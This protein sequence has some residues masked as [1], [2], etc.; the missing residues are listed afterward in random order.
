VVFA[1]AWRAV[2]AAISA[3]ISFV[4]A[5]KKRRFCRLRIARPLARFCRTLLRRPPA[6]GAAFA[7]CAAQEGSVTPKDFGKI[8]LGLPEAWEGSHMGHADF[9]VGKRIFAT[10]GYPDASSGMVRLTLSQQTELVKRAP[11]VFAP[12]PG[13]WGRKG[14][15]QVR[16]VAA[17]RRVLQPALLTAWANIAPRRLTARAA[18]RISPALARAYQ[19]YLRIVL[20]LPGTS[21]STSY[22]TPSV[23]VA[24]KLLSRWRTEAE[25]GLAIRCDFLDRQILLANADAF[26]LTD[27]YRDYPM[28]LVR[29]ERVDP[30]A[31][32]DLTRRAWRMVAPKKLL[33]STEDSERPVD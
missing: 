18:P 9:R 5:G 3:D 4:C 28:V 10:L 8:A 1:R 22:G 33:K 13:G 26:F 31:L 11:R 27:H 6:K 25:G 7:G 32:T 2:P 23:K 30:R 29:L 19:R 15:T 12:V 21:E 14:S 24:G 20:R 17:T 16:L